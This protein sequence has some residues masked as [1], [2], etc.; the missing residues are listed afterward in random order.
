MP[1]KKIDRFDAC[2][3]QSGNPYSKCCWPYHQGFAQGNQKQST[4][5]T[6]L[7]L[8]RSRYCAYALGLVDYVMATTHPDNTNYEGDKASWREDL[9]GFCRN[10]DFVGL[11]ID[12]FDVEANTVTFT[13]SLTQRGI[14][15]GFTEKSTFARGVDGRWLYLDGTA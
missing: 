10:T 13:A 3:C 4:A 15:S 6:P 1:V 12:D 9:L 2:P 14:N 7:T 11:K 5:P 8:M